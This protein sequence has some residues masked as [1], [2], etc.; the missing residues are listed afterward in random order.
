VIKWKN[1][2]DKNKK[3]PALMKQKCLI[4]CLTKFPVGKAGIS[5]LLKIMIILTILLV[6]FLSQMNFMMILLSVS[7]KKKKR[8]KKKK[9]IIMKDLSKN[10]MTSLNTNQW[11]MHIILLIL[12]LTNSKNIKS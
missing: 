12:V 1:K 8:K 9:V 4:S 10:M 5:S 11:K 3:K 7:R 6:T 2:F